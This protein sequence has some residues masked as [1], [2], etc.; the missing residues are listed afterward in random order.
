MHR[1]E[2]GGC[3][4]GRGYSGST[5]GSSGGR[6]GVNYQ[7]LLVRAG[8]T[9]RKESGVDRGTV[10]KAVPEG[11]CCAETMPALLREI[12]SE[13]A[14]WPDKRILLATPDVNNAYRNVRVAANQAHKF[15][16]AVGDILVEPWEVGPA[17]R[18]PREVDVK[19]N[20]G[21]WL[22]T[23]S[24]AAC[25]LTISSWPKFNTTRK[26]NAL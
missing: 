14:R 4:N 20:S 1:D 6:R 10:T 21:G 23:F 5:V 9:A 11:L 3:T 8:C 18:V 19:P 2:Q 25:S 12:T 15:C 7:R 24:S 22:K 17:T 13:R 16:Y 26:T